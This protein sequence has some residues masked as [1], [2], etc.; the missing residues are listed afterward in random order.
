MKIFIDRQNDCSN[1]TL[2]TWADVVAVDD[3]GNKISMKLK[4]ASV[5]IKAGD[6]VVLRT[7]NFDN[8]VKEYAVD[9]LVVSAPDMK[10]LVRESK[11]EGMKTS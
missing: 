11:D 5:V 2:S 4:E 10:E 9:S 7:R 3:S 8:V 6:I 1:S